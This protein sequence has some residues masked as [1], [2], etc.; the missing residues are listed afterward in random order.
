MPTLQLINGVL[1]TLGSSH[2]TATSQ[3][4]TDLCCTNHL[5]IRLIVKK[6]PGIPEHAPDTIVILLKI[7]LDDIHSPLL[8]KLIFS[9]PSALP[10][11]L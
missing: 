7:D 11:S 10:S 1:M 6:G 8:T 3:V 5:R 4:C 9:Y 2:Q